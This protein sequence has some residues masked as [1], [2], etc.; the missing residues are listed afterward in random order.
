VFPEFLEEP[1]EIVAR[2]LLGC[3]LVRTLDGHR[4][5][6]RIVETEAYDQ[7]D[8]ASHAFRGR[9]ARN[10]VMFGPCGHLYVYFTYGMHYCCN[11]VTG[12]E[13]EGS[14][15]LIRAAQPLEG[16]ETIEARRGVVAINATN[17]PAKLCQALAIDRALGGHDLRREPLELQRGDLLP[18]ETVSQSP[19]IGISK[20]TDRL[21]RFFITGNPYVSR[22]PGASRR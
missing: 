12:H 10:D 7:D 19:R 20:A 21:R 11:V 22:V 13:G 2:K 16:V 6:V 18:G 1:V 15:V 4:I 3:T 14:G 5:T 9:T 17:G 8:P